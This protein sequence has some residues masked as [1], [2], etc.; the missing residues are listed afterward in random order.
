MSIKEG[1]S[2]LEKREGQCANGHRN[3]T[4]R[5][6]INLREEITKSP[7]QEVSQKQKAQVLD[8]KHMR[9]QRPGWRHPHRAPGEVSGHSG[10]REDLKA[11]RKQSRPQTK[12]Q[13]SDGEHPA[14]QQD[15]KLVDLQHPEGK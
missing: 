8:G 7:I 10:Q 2:G 15:W 4:S 13:A 12:E 14:Q 5:E 9:A 3:R 11:S 6:K 1:E